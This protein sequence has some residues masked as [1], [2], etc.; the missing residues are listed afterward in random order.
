MSE[1]L[2]YK[3]KKNFGQTLVKYVGYQA[4]SSWL[5]APPFTLYSLILGLGPC[6]HIPHLLMA[7]HWALPRGVVRGRLQGCKRDKDSLLP[8]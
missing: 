5:W 8:S 7:P 3:V 2:S 4:V 6:R 1:D